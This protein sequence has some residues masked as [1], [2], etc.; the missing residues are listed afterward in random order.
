ME[1]DPPVGKQGV[2]DRDPR[3]LVPEGDAVTL[4]A[5]HA[6]A[7]ACLEVLEVA[8]GDRLEQ[9]ELRARRDDRG[10]LEERPG[11]VRQPRRA[12][13]HRLAHARR[14]RG[15]ARGERLGDVERVAARPAVQLG[16]IDAVRP[17]QALDRTRRERLEPDP[18]HRLAR[19]LAERE[20]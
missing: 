20:P 3:D 10:R 13:E 8:G 17:G 19:E 6:G 9:P 5:E 18:G 4:G 15:A 11:T 2:L 7:Q 12:G 14:E 16:R 1:R